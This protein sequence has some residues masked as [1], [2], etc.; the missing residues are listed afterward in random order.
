MD[1]PLKSLKI[2]STHNTFIKGQ[3]GGKLTIEPFIHQLELSKHMPVCMEIDISGM[4]TEGQLQI[5]HGTNGV[6]FSENDPD[7]KYKYIYDKKI[8]FHVFNIFNTVK[9]YFNDDNINFPIIFTIDLGHSIKSSNDK[10]KYL[11]NVT[12]IYNEVFNKNNTSFY[13]EFKNCSDSTP[14][15][16]MGKVLLRYKSNDLDNPIPHIDNIVGETGSSISFN[17]SHKNTKSLSRSDSLIRYYPSIITGNINETNDNHDKNNKFNTN[18]ISGEMTLV[19]GGIIKKIYHAIKNYGCNSNKGT[20]YCIKYSKIN[21]IIL[22]SVLNNDDNFKY[23]NFGAFNYFD[24]DPEDRDLVEKLFKTF[25][26]LNMKQIKNFYYNRGKNSNIGILHYDIIQIF[27][28]EKKNNTVLAGSRPSDL[29]KEQK[30]NLIITPEKKGTTKTA[31][32][33]GNRKRRRNKKSKK[34]KKPN[35]KNKTTNKP[36][37][38]TIKKKS[39]RKQTKKKTINKISKEN[40]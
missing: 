22:N 3:I 36:L 14:E 31:I 10:K 8:D 32:L 5:D 34:I 27:E 6:Y 16:L 37:R 24:V 13:Q 40:K 19:G 33:G 12:N 18:S 29:F 7:H 30:P 11:E 1:I 26:A 38:N 20:N 25:Y 35:K 23:I 9:T 21:S 28:N 15:S 17:G 2:Y 4:Q 39:K